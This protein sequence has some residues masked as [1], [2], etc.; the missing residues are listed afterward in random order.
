MSFDDLAKRIAKM[1]RELGNKEQ[2]QKVA[3]AAAEIVKERTN[4]GF[5]VAQNNGPKKRLKPLSANY[6]K[7]RKKLPLGPK[8]RPSRSNLNQTGEM[9]ESVKGKGSKNLAEVRLTGENNKK[10]AIDQV[11]A[12]RSFMNLAKSEI[13]KVVNIIEEQINNDIKKN[14][15]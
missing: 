12:G 6:K 3:T 7:Q 1:A 2:T 4:R 14:G 11:K 10:K 13:K 9:V 15:L 5:G 8:A